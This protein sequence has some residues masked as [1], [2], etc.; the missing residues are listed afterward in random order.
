MIF[1]VQCAVTHARSILPLFQK[2]CNFRF[3]ESQIYLSLTDGQFRRALA[4]PAMTSTLIPLG[5][6]F[7]SEV[8]AL[9]KK[10]VWQSS[11][12]VYL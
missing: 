12:G 4:P 9:Y 11:S 6:N 7:S 3:G 8:E 1:H 2:R 10:K 5:N